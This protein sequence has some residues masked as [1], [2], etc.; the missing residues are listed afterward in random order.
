M[1]TNLVRARR[2]AQSLGGLFGLV[3]GGTLLAS[4]PLPAV[5]IMLAAMTLLTNSLIPKSGSK[6][7][8]ED[9][10]FHRRQSTGEQQWPRTR[11]LQ[12]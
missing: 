7:F 6:M 9:S 11:P 4:R 8:C 2:L 1:L 5:A 3:I 12:R 10:Q